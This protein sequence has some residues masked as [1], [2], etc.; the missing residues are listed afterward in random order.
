MPRCSYTLSVFTPAA[1]ASVR[2]S[3]L[4]TAAIARSILCGESGRSLRISQVAFPCSSRCDRSCRLAFARCRVRSL[5]P[6]CEI[7]PFADGRVK[8]LERDRHRATT[9]RPPL[10][11]AIFSERA[12]PGRN[13]RLPIRRVAI[14]APHVEPIKQIPHRRVDLLNGDLPVGA[15]RRTLPQAR[16]PTCNRSRSPSQRWRWSRGT[17]RHQNRA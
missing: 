2:A 9:V 10:N 5:W 3:Q 6:S 12:R 17:G 11:H 7:V 13:P 16:R 14:T 8:V 4:N 15:P 1:T